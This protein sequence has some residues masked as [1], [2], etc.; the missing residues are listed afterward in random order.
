MKKLIAF[1]GLFLLA[2]CAS[3]H[4][5]LSEVIS[6][7]AGARIEVDGNYIG[8]APLTINN[9]WRVLITDRVTFPLD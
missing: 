1:L 6:E 3:T 9:M 4:T 7:P 2:G 8:N 5:Y